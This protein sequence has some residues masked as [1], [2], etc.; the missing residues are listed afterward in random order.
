MFFPVEPINFLLP[1]SDVTLEDVGLTGEFS[2]EISKE[3]LKAEWLKD[4]KPIKRGEKYNMV[5]E[6]TVHKLVIENALAEDEAEY[7]VVFREDAKSKAKL[8]IHG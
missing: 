6:A 7:T 3:G 5:D 1:L 2:C 8:V 4:G